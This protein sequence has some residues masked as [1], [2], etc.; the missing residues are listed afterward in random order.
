MDLD[1]IDDR[2]NTNVGDDAVD[3]SSTP[4]SEERMT[5]SPDALTDGAE[6]LGRLPALPGDGRLDQALLSDDVVGHAGLGHALREFVAVWD[7]RG[8]QYREHLSALETALCTASAGYSDTDDSAADEFRR[9]RT[10]SAQPARQLDQVSTEAANT[11]LEHRS[12]SR[13][14]DRHGG[15]CRR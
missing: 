7:Q 13:N 5:T 2:A 6:Q 9:I 10:G 4:Q 12:P 8:Q 14:E 1:D 15:P 3:R 11:R